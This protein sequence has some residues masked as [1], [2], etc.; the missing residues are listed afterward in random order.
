MTTALPP[1]VDSSWHEAS[2][3]E[4]VERMKNKTIAL[5]GAGIVAASALALGGGGSRRARTRRAARTAEHHDGERR[6]AY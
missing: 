6:R 3:I 5:A 2:T 4:G 1:T